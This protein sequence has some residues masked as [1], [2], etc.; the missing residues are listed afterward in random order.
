MSAEMRAVSAAGSVCDRALALAASGFAVFPLAPR[1]KVP[2]AGS[3]GVTDATCDPATIAAMFE[4]HPE[5]NIALACGDVSGG[6]FALDVDPRNG[7][8]GSLA[9]LTAKYGALPQTVTARTGGH[10]DGRHF[11]YGKPPGTRLRSKLGRHYRGIDVLGDGRHIVAAGS[12]HPDTARQYEWLHAPG[13]YRIADAPA[14]LLELLTVLP[15]P[16]PVADAVSLIKPVSGTELDSAKERART[17]LETAPRAIQGRNGSGTLLK[18]AIY[19]TC[20]LKLPED[21]SAELLRADYNHRCD[22][23][24][25]PEDI[26]HKVKCAARGTIAQKQAASD[27]V[28]ERL[29]AR[30]AVHQGED[31]AATMSS[32]GPVVVED[33]HA[34]RKTSRTK[35]HRYSFTPGDRAPAGEAKKVRAVDVAADLYA[36]KDWSGVLQHDE[37]RDVIH[38]V[39]PPVQ[40]DAEGAEGLSDADVERVTHWFGAQ[41]MTVRSEVVRHAIE[42][43]AKRR[44]YH[45]V[46][47]YLASLP[48]ATDAGR[49]ALATYA[50]DVFGNADPIVGE[51]VKKTMI[52]AVRRILRPGTKVDTLLILKGPQGY[53]KSKWIQE[54]FGAQFFKD[55]LP[56][57]KNDAA[58]SHGLVG[59]W[60]VEVGELD[61]VL[62]AENTTSKVFLSREEDCY[63]PP[64]GQRDVRR[65][66]QCVFIGTTNDD[67]FLTDAT[68]G[69]RYWVVSV[70]REID[71]AYVRSVRDSVW[72]AALE[73]AND[74]T[75]PHWFNDARG[76]LD[77]SREPFESRDAWHELIVDYVTGKSFV[78]WEDVYSAGVARGMTDAMA[79]ASRREM[80]R[81]INVLKRLKCTQGH[82]PIDG[83]RTYGWLVPPTLA[84]AS[85]SPGER[86]R[87]ESTAVVGRLRGV[88]K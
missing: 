10:P 67:D 51:M 12:V 74:M 55:Q 40:L 24:W 49:A 11:L 38:A 42:L 18:V 25:S 32:T 68:G 7:G 35:G 19:L 64:Y 23:P 39:D 56:D 28:N 78:R 48:P 61:R 87:S 33:P 81:V 41:N 31:L 43:V 71:L 22:P 6:V 50:K 44:S 54:H 63:H 57:L 21:V 82:A 76:D 79:K 72:A 83:R 75:I 3:N 27:A 45:P 15:S 37:F 69:R 20:S 60:A 4:G 47:E 53:F 65:K 80:R 73:C 36:H 16:S 66:R 9:K 34:A 85:P 13:D 84:N 26:M 52:A 58:A 62:R 29:A 1:D 88:G 59:F 86:A 70:S 14:W 5:A 46:R 2:L 17:Y 8:V 77:A 30:L